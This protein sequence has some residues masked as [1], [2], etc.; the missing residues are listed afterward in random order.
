[1]E[2]ETATCARCFKTARENAIRTSQNKKETLLEEIKGHFQESKRALS[3]S[4]KVLCTL[5]FVSAPLVPPLPPPPNK[6]P[7]LIS[8][9]K[10]RFFKKKK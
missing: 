10:T 1:M 8:S 9:D 6:I 7:F 3:E 2:I 5:I 4:K